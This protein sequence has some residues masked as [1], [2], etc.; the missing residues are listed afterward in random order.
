MNTEHPAPLCHIEPE[1]DATN[2]PPNI[3][4]GTGTGPYGR[5]IMPGTVGPN[6][7]DGGEAPFVYLST[8]SGAGHRAHRTM[9][10]LAEALGL[11]PRPNS[12]TEHPG[13]G[14]RVTL[15]SDQRLETGDS[16]TH[17]E[18]TVD[19][20]FVRVATAVAHVVLIVS[21]LPLPPGVDLKAHIDHSLDWG[22]FSMGRIPLVV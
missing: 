7:R 9:P 17:F 21:Y 6:R 11:D 16:A 19:P 2:A 1:P 22:R 5:V 3:H 8:L 12:T 20:G 10:L 15:A 4:T 14:A 18:A 13:A